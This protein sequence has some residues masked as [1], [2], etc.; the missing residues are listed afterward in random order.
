MPTQLQDFDGVTTSV[1]RQALS[2]TTC[3][4][5]A[6]VRLQADRLVLGLLILLAIISV[7]LAPLDGTWWAAG[8]TFAAGALFCGIR[9]QCGQC[10]VTR[11]AA[12]V[13]LHAL[14][15]L[16]IWQGGRMYD[17]NLLTFLVMTALIAYQDWTCIAAGLAVFCV[18]HGGLEVSGLQENEFAYGQP[19]TQMSLHEGL[20]LLLVAAHAALCGGL[21]IL[22]QQRILR[23]A[24]TTADLARAR[25]RLTS[26]LSARR[27]A[28]IQLT[29]AR[30]Q[31]E[32][33]A[34]AKADF[35]AVM[36]HELRTP[37]NGILGM[38]RLLADSQLDP[39]QREMV[40]AVLVSGDA[41]LDIIGDVLDYSKMEAGR[42]TIDPTPCDL[43]RVCEAVLDIVAPKAEEK[44]IALILR[45]PP[46]VP[47]RFV[48]DAARLRQ[49]LL[50]LVS[51]AIKFTATGRVMLTVSM[52]TDQLHFSVSDTG[53]GITSGQ[54]RS[55]FQPFMQAEVGIS[56]TYG[57][58]GLGLVI[59][60]RLVELMQGTIGV[61]SQPGAGS[62]F[63]CQ[64]PLKVDLSP[65]T[66]TRLMPSDCQHVLVLDGDS[67]RRAALVEFI[68]ESGWRC[69]GREEAP[70]HLEGF[71]AIVVD[72]RF[73]AARTLLAEWHQRMP[74]LRCILLVG[75]TTSSAPALPGIVHVRKPMHADAMTQ[76]LAPD[77]ERRFV[78]PIP[79]P[80]QSSNVNQG[81]VLLVND[82]Y[83]TLHQMA[84]QVRG[85]GFHVVTAVDGVQALQLA[86]EQ[87]FSVVLTD[88]HLP[89]LTA[90][91]L[92]ATLRRSSGPNRETP[93]LACI[94]ASTSHE[95]S[96]ALTLGVDGLLTSPLENSALAAA[97]ERWTR[98]GSRP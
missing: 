31:A 4:I 44:D 59:S 93:V 18:I 83:L 46:L 65:A 12:A 51:N 32:A 20:H 38:S 14:V 28:Q 15:A 40:D 78:M 98:N 55:L 61:D 7:A 68:A 41:L 87:P 6:P 76:A 92:T 24:R 53:I 67:E 49:V 72:D 25:D 48:A 23:V 94:A 42:L 82:H 33:A 27:Q 81:T 5:L 63:W 16:L 30:D 85:L 47:R 8:V 84:D 54:L 62:T 79:I 17:P 34:R 77:A 88:A 52:R 58:T 3:E 91:Q 45:W 90:K 89:D 80:I 37:M 11:H 69:Q 74:R 10:A 73:P 95:V 86:T 21:A 75:M 29:E 19:T 64:L 71:T 96:E 39:E 66:S 43:R 1:V 57:G 2:G 60:K 36:S 13:I 26:E 97:L 70:D 22:S 56:R 9:W 35:L 50:N